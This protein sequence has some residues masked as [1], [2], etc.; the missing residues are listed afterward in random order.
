MILLVISMVSVCITGYDSHYMIDENEKLKLQV[1]MALYENEDSERN[2]SSI[3]KSLNEKNYKISRILSTLEQE[4][5]AD[6]TVERHPRLT[7]GGMEMIKCYKYKVDI[8]INHL[9]YEGISEKNARKDAVMW[10]L[11]TSD[12]TMKVLDEANERYRIKNE[13]RGECAF[14]GNILCKLMRDGDYKFSYVFY[15]MC[16][17]DGNVL[18]MANNGFENPCTLSVRKGKG[19]IRLKAKRVSANSAV[20]GHMMMGEVSRVMYFDGIDYK[21]AVKEGDEILIPANTIQFVN[22]GTG[23]GQFMNGTVNMKM[24]CSVGNMHMPESVAL[25]SVTI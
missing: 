8:F 21:E 7:E 20:N 9:L 4:G 6:K 18:S 12:E 16:S 11:N 10:A 1:L 23:I 14:S 22:T 25:F 15:R 3:A 2:V 24:Q 19:S 5:L 13:L 17:E